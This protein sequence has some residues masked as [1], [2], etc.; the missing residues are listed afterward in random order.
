MAD[1]QWREIIKDQPEQDQRILGKFSVGASRIV[2]YNRFCY[3]L[4]GLT[5][6]KPIPKRTS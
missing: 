3:E 5:H 1:E 2:T 6:W 4:W